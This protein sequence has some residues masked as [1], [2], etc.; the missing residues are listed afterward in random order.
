MSWPDQ[1]P[2]Y[3]PPAVWEFA[4]ELRASER[5][6]KAEAAALGRLLGLGMAGTWESLAK[7]G[8]EDPT[9]WRLILDLCVTSV[10]GSVFNPS[11]RAG[12]S[13]ARELLP[14][15]A[16]S[17][18]ALAAMVAEF[19]ELRN[20]Y[21]ITAP[22]ELSDIQ[23]LLEGARYCAPPNLEQ[24][25]LAAFE[26]AL[27]RVEVPN[28]F[29]CLASA[30]D[31]FEVNPGRP[32]EAYATT[33]KTGQIPQWVRAIDARWRI[34]LPRRLNLTDTQLARVGCAVLGLTVTRVA[35]K[36]ARAIKTPDLLSDSVIFFE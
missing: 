2:Q 4:Q 22:L 5:T 17:A 20:R 27:S 24:W 33:P 18:A 34:Y 26:R 11:L 10:A 15:I 29:D 16:A 14:R 31:G 12:L 7:R 32:H 21:G 6:S 3:L 35:V 23:S 30:A 1:C 28:L 25:H 19:N 8:I 9:S 13:A 36:R